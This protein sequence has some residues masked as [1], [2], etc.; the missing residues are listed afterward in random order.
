MRRL[1][2]GRTLQVALV[3]LTFA[4]GLVA[5]LGVASL[6]DTRQEYEDHLATSYELEVAA[7]RMLAAGV[8]EEAALR[9]RADSAELDAAA[10]AFERE[11]AAALALAGEDSESARLVRQREQAQD[12]IR[13]AAR[14]SRRRSGSRDPIGSAL[15]AARTASAQLAARQRER[16]EEARAEVR[17]DTRRSALTAAGAGGLALLAALALVAALVAGM[18]RP[19]EDLVGATRQLSAGDLHKRVHPE[20]PRELRDLGE[21]F[22]AMAGDLDSA[23]RRID[24][25]RRRLAVTVESLSEALVT[26]DAEGGV[27]AANPRAGDLVPELRPGAPAHGEGSPLPPL[28]EALDTEVL[29]EAGGRTLAVTAATLG[30]EEGGAVWTIRD[31][32]ERAR[33]ERLKSEFVA[34]A[35]HELRSPL[36]SIKGFAELLGRSRTLDERQ[37]EF[38]EVI[39]LSTNRLVDLVN[40]LLDV[41]RA[42]AGKIEL[43]RRPVDLGE[44][45]REIATLMTP[46]LEGKRQRIELDIPF[47]LPRAYAD[48][49]RVRQILTNLLTNAHLYTDEG[50]VLKVSVDHD[51][52]W[53]LLEVSDSG[54]GM[55]P[56]ELGHVFDRFYR[57]EDGGM[58]PGTGLGLSIVK[59]LVDLHEGRIAV[60]SQRGVG[61]TFT[62]RLPR[63][64]AAGSE[65]APRLA[66]RGK[67]VLVVDNEPDIAALIARQLEP[68]GVKPVTV[69]SGAEA[70][71][72]L[73]HGYFDA[74]TLDLFMPGMSGFE[75]LRLIRSD[76]EIENVPVV[77][78]SVL[79]GREAL[80][81]EWTVTKPIDSEELADA[82]GGAVLAGRTRVLVIGRAALRAEVTAA[83]DGL[84]I[85]HRWET[86]ARAAARACEEERFEVAL[87]DAAM[88]GAEGALGAVEL[89]GRRLARKVILFS[90]GD[91]T[92]GH[93]SL[94]PDPVPIEQAASAVVDAL[95]AG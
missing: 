73:R 28:A 21:A 7:S 9:A 71:E 3:T 87:V 67:R 76:P 55:G 56:D 10:G 43:N 57:G 32:S 46:R 24:E 64:P 91:D 29:V 81:G 93:A 31:I 89:R 18:R 86:S 65:P 66:I 52:G 49:A 75:V 36:T 63:Q 92:A 84:G 30:G 23:Q 83:L 27:M 94:G 2:I 17:D 68:F 11:A 72:R 58:A 25:E 13:R 79:S 82:L 1:S 44:Q 38:V 5:A 6:Y 74:V 80:A 41:A 39:I 53:M 22:N 69:T 47:G 88:R 77:V 90:A 12:A 20:G 95:G 42:E 78:V 60:A 4:L 35:S 14:R 15:L 50:G 34:T 33:L 45:V 40:D 26:T 37:R 51:D 61:S 85:S 48:P 16:R 8:V 54:R 19:L 62:V 70:V 59:S